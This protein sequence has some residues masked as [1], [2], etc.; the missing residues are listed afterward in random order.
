MR[1][2][3]IYEGP[4]DALA[5]LFTEADDSESEI[6]RYRNLGEVLVARRH[7]AIVGH[8]Q[9]VEMDEPGEFELKSLAVLEEYRSQGIG[10]ALVGSVID[11]CRGREARLLVVAT[12][13][14]SIPALQFYQRQ[15][16]R[17]RR[18]VRDFYTSERGYRAL[19]LNGIPLLDGVILDLEL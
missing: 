18:V 5:S 8:A 12:A 19:T 2:F 9:V 16:F 7:G 6:A 15:G 1:E 14:A 3:G 11:F 13:A 17:I 4:R 10:A